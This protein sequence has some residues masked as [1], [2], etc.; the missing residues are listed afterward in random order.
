M[1]GLVSPRQ[2]GLRLWLQG[3]EM[4][5]VLLRIALV[6]AAASAAAAPPSPMEVP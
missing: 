3:G 1:C 4:P 6:F 5:G 2:V